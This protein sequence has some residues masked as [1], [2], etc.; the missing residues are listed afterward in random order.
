MIGADLA[1]LGFLLG[2]DLFCDGT[3]RVEAAARG[4]VE[5][6]GHIPFED[7]ALALEVRVR[8]G[9]GRHQ[10]LGVGMQRVLE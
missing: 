1:E 10:G 5:R 3:A 4:R 9:N 2:A 7:G 6:A 8:D